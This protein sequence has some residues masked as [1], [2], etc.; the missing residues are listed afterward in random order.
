MIEVLPGGQPPAKRVE[1][2]DH[3][4]Y[5][6]HFL[7]AG[8]DVDAG[9]PHLAAR[10]YDSGS[11]HPDR[12]RLSGTVGSQQTEELAVLNLEVECIYCSRAARIDFGEAPRLDCQALLRGALLGRTLLLRLGRCHRSIS[13]ATRC[14]GSL[15]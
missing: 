3:A 13:Y 11:E 6:L 10:G 15:N 2:G 14:P 8:P 12:G 5:P 7:L 1:L 4:D 9:D